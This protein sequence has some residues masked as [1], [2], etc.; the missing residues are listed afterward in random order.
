VEIQEAILKPF[1]GHKTPS[2]GVC[3]GEFSSAWKS[4]YPLT[5]LLHLPAGVAGCKNT[6]SM[7]INKQAFSSAKSFAQCVF[8]GATV[9]DSQRAKKSKRLITKYLK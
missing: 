8:M 1:D 7:K 2:F 6:K 9:I 5:P 3:C 4:S